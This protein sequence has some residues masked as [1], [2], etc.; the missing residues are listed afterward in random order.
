MNVVF[1]RW[2]RRG[3][4]GGGGCVEKAEE[5]TRRRGEGM[6]RGERVRTQASPSAQDLAHSRVSSSELTRGQRDRRPRDHCITLVHKCVCVKTARAAATR[7]PFKHESIRHTWLLEPCWARRHTKDNTAAALSRTECCLSR[8][9]RGGAR[10]E[11]GRETERS[12][13]PVLL[14]AMPPSVPMLTFTF[15]AII[16]GSA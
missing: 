12:A 4:G 5:V 7:T 13:P 6:K 1:V 8:D 2:R 9:R 11:E 14:T 15:S 3:G 10:G 16:F